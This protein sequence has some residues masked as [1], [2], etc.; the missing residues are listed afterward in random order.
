MYTF[1]SRA[2]LI[3]NIVLWLASVFLV[4]AISA[5][6]SGNSA[7]NLMIKREIPLI[8]FHNCVFATHNVDA[9]NKAMIE[10]MNGR[11]AAPVV[12]IPEDVR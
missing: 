9:C 4:A 7:M 10:E 11:K 2:K 8:D 12:V 5:Y 6:V 1:S 3:G